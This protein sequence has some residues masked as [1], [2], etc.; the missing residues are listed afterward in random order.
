MIFGIKEV[1]NDLGE[2][3]SDKCSACKSSELYHF[4]KITRFLVV[5]FIN[6]VPL[7][8]RF[9]AVCCGCEDTLA[10]D[11]R[12]GRATARKNF[13]KR[14]IAIAA[15]TALKLAAAAVIV[16]AAVT[17]PLTIRIPL[18]TR[19]ETLKN[20]I[21]ETEDGL[22][23]IQDRDGNVLGIVQI[24][25]GERTLTYYDD[26]SVLVKEPGA[27]GSFKMHESRQEATNDAEQDDIFLVRIPDNP[28]VLEDRYGIPVRVY[29]YDSENDTLGYA[30]GIDD[31]STITY[32]ADKVIYP[33]KYYSSSAEEPTSY[34]MVLYFAGDKQLL[35]TFIPE[36]S[37]GETNQFVS[38]TVDEMKDSRIQTETQ[39][40]FDTDAINM[41]KQAGLTDQSSAQ[42]I[43][44]FIDQDSADPLLITNYEYF[45]NTKVVTNTT[46][47]MPD[48]N[49]DMQSVS[50]VFNVTA[51]N[52]YYIVSAAEQ[53]E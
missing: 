25:E 39:Y 17:L 26:V 44:N 8:S 31:L 46:L 1:R 19:P 9:E 50:Q 28:G 29:H 33:F 10:V 3:S 12:S 11:N 42:D 18:D 51:R 2:F 41:A 35:T 5:F 30:R 24:E 45:E 6:L 21:T 36:L 48:S 27:D 52:G 40:V 32:S 14:R 47:T 23:G 15:K 22:Y 43:L 16:A 20:L 7:G 13:N 34:V 53:A 4:Y 37:T 38:L 49:G